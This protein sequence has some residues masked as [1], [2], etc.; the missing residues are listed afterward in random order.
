M[1]SSLCFHTTEQRYKANDKTKEKNERI[2][3]MTIIVLKACAEVSQLNVIFLCVGCRINDDLAL[4]STNM[5]TKI[6]Y[7]YKIF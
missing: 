4:V 6:G 2:F 7:H 3:A 1:S 5:N